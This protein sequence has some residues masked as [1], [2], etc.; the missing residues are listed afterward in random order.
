MS[1][2]LSSKGMKSFGRYGSVGFELLLSIA[3]GYYL[4][5][6]ADGKLGTHWISLLGFLLGCYAGFRA[7]FKAGKAMQRDAVT[8]KPLQVVVVG[9]IS[10]ALLVLGL[11]LLVRYIVG[12]S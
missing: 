11:L 6:L 10:A 1:T 8:V 7:L 9:V 12:R 2:F 5:H 4:G 3:I